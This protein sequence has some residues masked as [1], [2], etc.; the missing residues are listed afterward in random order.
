VSGT[1]FAHAGSN[2]LLRQR[3]AIESIVAVKSI[4]IHLQFECI[5][6]KGLPNRG[7][8]RPCACSLGFR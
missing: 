7:D 5:L 8:W 1:A 6:T 2:D 4:Q 3:Q